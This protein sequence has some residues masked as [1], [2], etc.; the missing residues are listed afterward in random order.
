MNI[1]NFMENLKERVVSLYKKIQKIPFYCLQKRDPNKLFEVKKGSCFEKN[2]YLGRA[3]EKLGIPVKYLEMKF[4]W[5]DLPIPPRI[6]KKYRGNKTGLHLALEIKLNDK[7]L[8][9]DATWDPLLGKGGFPITKRWDGKSNTKLA[10]KPLSI[11]PSE[12]SLERTIVSENKEFFE[13]LNKYLE[14]IR[15]QKC[16]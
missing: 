4:N 10:V 15:K 14:K 12:N 13:A 8:K 11:N 5:E 6:L 2:V 3:Y 7:W 16:S 9:V 1:N